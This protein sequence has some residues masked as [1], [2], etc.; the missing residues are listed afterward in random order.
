MYIGRIHSSDIPD[1]TRITTFIVD[2]EKDGEKRVMK[3]HVI[4]RNINTCLK[5]IQKQINN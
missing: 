5:N 1:T 2:E 4:E 3:H